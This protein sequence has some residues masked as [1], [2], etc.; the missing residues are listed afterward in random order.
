M[1]RKLKQV[2]KL[3]K[4]ESK[5]IK[6]GPFLSDLLFC[7]LLIHRNIQHCFELDMMQ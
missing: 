5:E 6:I 1:I 2:Q 4:L 3:V 7:L